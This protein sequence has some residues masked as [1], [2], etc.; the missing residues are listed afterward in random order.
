MAGGGGKDD[1]KNS[2]NMW[3]LG[4]GSSIDNGV[5]ADGGLIKRVENI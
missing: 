4:E 3:M 1:G 2:A 5:V